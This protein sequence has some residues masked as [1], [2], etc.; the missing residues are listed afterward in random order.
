MAGSSSQKP[1]LVLQ[2]APRSFSKPKSKYIFKTH[3]QN[4][5]SMEGFFH[6]D[7]LHSCFLQTHTTN[8]GI[9]PNPSLIIL[10]ASKLFPTNWHYKPWDI[11]KPQSYYSIILSTIL[12][13][14]RSVK[15]K[16]FKLHHHPDL[17]TP[18]AQSKKSSILQTVNNI[19]MN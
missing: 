3:F 10:P 5:L 15:L 18:L 1:L 13:T 2:I 8:H 12:E 6:E 4:I 17:D 7:Q 19:Y 16:H 14:T 9:V 11:T